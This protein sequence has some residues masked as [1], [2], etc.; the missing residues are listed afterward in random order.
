M[1]LTGRSLLAGGGRFSGRRPTPATK[2]KPPHGF[3]SRAD[4]L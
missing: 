2:E 3:P 1:D 4:C